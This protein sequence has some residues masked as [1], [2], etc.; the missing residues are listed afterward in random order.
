MH[1]KATTDLPIM[2][3]DLAVLLLLLLL[4]LAFKRISVGY[5]EDAYSLPVRKGDDC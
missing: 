2:P 1:A 5:S 4:V 3:D